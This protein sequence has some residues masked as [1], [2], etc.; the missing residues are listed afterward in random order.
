MYRHIK[1][2]DNPSTK[3]HILKSE[4]AIDHLLSKYNE[5]ELINLAREVRE[6]YYR[7]DS[8]S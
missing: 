4:M 2:E 7:D 3:R 1:T 8:I 5:H 6:I